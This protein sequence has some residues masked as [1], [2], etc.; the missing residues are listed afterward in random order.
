MPEPRIFA[1]GRGGWEESLE[2]YERHK[3]AP[4][5]PS[6][7]DIAMEIAPGV[8]AAVLATGDMVRTD[9]R[10]HAQVAYGAYVAVWRDRERPVPEA[11][12]SRVRLLGKRVRVTV[13][14]SVVTEGMFLG[15]GEGGDFEIQ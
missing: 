4:L 11:R 14:E 1:L 9:G 7:A 12:K 5:D 13:D 10:T 2:Y 8:R 15:F 3:G 6:Y